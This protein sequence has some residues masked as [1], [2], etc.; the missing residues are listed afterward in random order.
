MK[1]LTVT[2]W[3]ACLIENSDNNTVV[4]KLLFTSIVL[5]LLYCTVLYFKRERYS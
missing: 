5:Q 2:K 3:I 1:V 4:N